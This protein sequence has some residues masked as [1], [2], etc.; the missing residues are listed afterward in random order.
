MF[1]QFIME[2]STTIQLNSWVQ[3]LI[4]SLKQKKKLDLAIKSNKEL[5][6]VSQIIRQ[7]ER[8]KVLAMEN[9]SWVDF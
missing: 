9:N 3:S 5:Y 6:N 8:K 1:K 2:L 4:A 7:T